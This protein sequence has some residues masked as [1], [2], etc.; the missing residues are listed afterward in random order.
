MI[1]VEKCWCT[2]TGIEIASLGVQVHGGMG[3]VEETGAAQYL[4]D[5]RITTIYE[6]TTGIQAMDLVG[7]K[8]AREGGATAKAWIAEL[9]KL[10]GELAGHPEIRKGLAEGVKAL[11]D[12]IAFIVGAKDPRVQFAGAVPFLKLMGIVAGGWQMARAALAAEKKMP[13]DKAFYEAKI[14]TT[15]FYADHVLVQAP[16][17]RNTVVS[18]A[19]GVMALSE[20]QFLAA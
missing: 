17:L 5:A 7:R 16:A 19:A 13:E 9:K 4:R 1:P 14:A 15:R 8:I 18:G 6:G 2:E 12:C 3:F 20:D 11:E 10:D